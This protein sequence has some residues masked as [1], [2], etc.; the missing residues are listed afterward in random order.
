[1]SAFLMEHG[2]VV[3]AHSAARLGMFEKLQELVNADAGIVHFRGV[4]GQT[5]LHCASTIEIADYLLEH[6]ADID[7]RDVQHESTAAQHMLRVAQ[8]R[9]Y[10]GTASRSLAIS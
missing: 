5:P 9:H 2:A 7:A 1:M 4:N 6:G 3:D 8:A 10:L